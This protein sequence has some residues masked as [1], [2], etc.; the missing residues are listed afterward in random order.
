MLNAWQRKLRAN[1]PE[2]AEH[3]TQ[4][5]EAGANGAKRVSEAENFRKGQM[6]Q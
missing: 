5:G 1:A 6:G 2:Q 3:R 4:R